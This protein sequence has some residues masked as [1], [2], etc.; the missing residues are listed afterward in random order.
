MSERLVGSDG[1]ESRSDPARAPVHQTN[2][3]AWGIALAPLVW[4]AALVWW[5][6]TAP[7]SGWGVTFAM[8]ASVVAS[9]VATRRDVRTLRNHS[10]GTERSFPVAVLLLYVIAAPVYLI[11]R[12]RKAS[13]SALIPVAWFMCMAVS[14]FSVAFVP[15]SEVKGVELDLAEDLYV[16]TSRA[17]R[18]D[19]PNDADYSVGS[20]VVCHVDN[21]GEPPHEVVVE[22]GANGDYTWEVKP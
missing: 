6:I 7:P 14:V 2:K 8:A 3:W 22:M 10:P 15:A 17:M 21:H 12:T 13:T 19:C 1:T 9:A 4:G 20:S 18:V 11:Y 16:S 5:T